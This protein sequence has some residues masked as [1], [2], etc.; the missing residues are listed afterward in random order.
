MNIKKMKKAQIK[1]FLSM[2]LIAWQRKIKSKIFWQNKNKENSKCPE[3]VKTK[4]DQNWKPNK[5]KPERTNR[6][7]INKRKMKKIDFVN[8]V[9]THTI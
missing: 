4:K 9:I 3:F 8:I 2:L 7:K 6:V 1:K 5:N